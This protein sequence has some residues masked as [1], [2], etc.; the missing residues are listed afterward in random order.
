MFDSSITVRRCLIHLGLA[1]AI[2]T[3]ALAN[4]AESTQQKTQKLQILET[5]KSQ[6]PMKAGRIWLPLFHGEAPSGYSRNGPL[7]LYG[8]A[9][10]SDTGAEKYNTLRKLK[11]QIPITALKAGTKIKN[12]ML[13]VRMHQGS[14]F[15][16]TVSRWTPPSDRTDQL[17]EVSDKLSW[18]DVSHNAA[19][20][21]GFS[22]LNGLIYDPGKTLYVL[23]IFL[24]AS[25][26]LPRQGGKVGRIQLVGVA[27]EYEEH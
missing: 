5:V 7:L 4:A 1:V 12:V 25:S 15:N 26:Q 8:P 23:D 19:K 6:T 22:G 20:V 11:L 10:Q 27:V 13:Y 3:P 14:S 21:Y 24:T 9:I 18:D 17:A 16:A 2:L